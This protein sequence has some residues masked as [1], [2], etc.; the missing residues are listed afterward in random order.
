MGSGSIDHVFLNSELVGGEWSASC[1]G[2]FTPSNKRIGGWVEPNEDVE[3]LEDVKVLDHI[4]TRTPIP[5]PFN[6]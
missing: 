3:D 4:G 1:P 2:R 6:P 5:R